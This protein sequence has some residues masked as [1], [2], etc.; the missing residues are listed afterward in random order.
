MRGGPHAI[1][2]IAWGT[3]EEKWP[4]EYHERPSTFPHHG[5]PCSKEV[6]PSRL[7]FR[8]GEGK[9]KALPL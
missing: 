8:E 2:G 1:H 6:V 9:M 4:H 5:S 3:R 7:V